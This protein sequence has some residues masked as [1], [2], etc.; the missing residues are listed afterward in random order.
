MP[1]IDPLII[2]KFTFSSIMDHLHKQNESNLILSFNLI[3]FISKLS[4]K[5]SLF[6]K[7]IPLDNLL[8]VG[9]A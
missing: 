7:V 2:S 1:T 5:V 9:S 4:F 6:S 8:T 3:W